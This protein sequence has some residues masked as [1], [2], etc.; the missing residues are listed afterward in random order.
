MKYTRRFFYLA[1]TLTVLLIAVGYLLEGLPWVSALV[2]ALGILWSFCQWRK[3]HWFN[4]LALIALSGI[5]LA[6]VFLSVQ[7]QLLL[8]GISL[9]MVA[10]DLGLFAARLQEYSES[11][12]LIT[13]ER[14]HLFRLLQVFVLGIALAEAGLLIQIRITFGWGFLLALL[15]FWGL[16]N[17]LK[18]FRRETD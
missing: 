1:I 13:Q 17:I 12:L 3:Q 18:Y 2:L 7:V 5:V 4:H 14:A 10:W 8:F 11:V 6:G 16:S 9:A 15:G